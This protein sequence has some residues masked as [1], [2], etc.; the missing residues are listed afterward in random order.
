MVTGEQRAALREDQ[1]A[2]LM[3][4]RAGIRSDTPGPSPQS[5]YSGKTLFKCKIQPV[6]YWF[7]NFKNF[8]LDV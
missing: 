6:Q 3:R 1:Q 5:V 4:A 2:A 7:Q 8:Y